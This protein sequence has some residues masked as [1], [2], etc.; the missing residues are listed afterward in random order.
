[1]GQPRNIIP[2]MDLTVS[3]CILPFLR[4]RAQIEQLART[5][6]LHD[7]VED[8]G[9]ITLGTADIERLTEA[10]RKRQVPSWAES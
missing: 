3:G 2:G 9:S 5:K 7:P 10:G 4:S 6:Y 8:P 1:M